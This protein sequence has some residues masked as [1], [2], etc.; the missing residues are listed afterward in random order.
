[1][2]T[3]LFKDT[4]PLTPR[5]KRTRNTPN[6]K[7]PKINSKKN[8]KNMISELKLLEE[9]RMKKLNAMEKIGKS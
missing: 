4:M 9:I 7:K 3:H 2:K 6:R 5:R 1:M 8:M